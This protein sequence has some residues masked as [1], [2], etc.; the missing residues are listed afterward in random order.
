MKLR[1]V[2][3]HSD[4]K[5]LND[6]YRYECEHFENLLIIIGEKSD[7]NKKY[8]NTALFFSPTKKSLGRIIKICQDANLI[9]LNDLT[10]F[11]CKI[12][13]ALPQNI[14]IAWRFF[15][16]E[17]YG[18]KKKLFLSE[19][20]KQ[21]WQPG[22]S[23]F[24][25]LVK[26]KI[27]ILFK[28]AMTGQYHKKQDFEI[29][30]Q[31]INLFFGLFKDEYLL[32]KTFWP[33]LPP[34]LGL[35]IGLNKVNFR[36]I[37]CPKKSMIILGNSRNNFN[38]H[39]DIIDIVESLSHPKN[40]SF[41]L[42]FNYGVESPYAEEIRRRALKIPTVEIVND[43]M[44]AEA[45]E[46]LYKNASAL[47]LNAYRQMAVGNILA[48]FRNGVKVY[49][50]EKNITMQWLLREG[51]FV[52]PITSLANDIEKDNFKLTPAEIEHNIAQLAKLM[53]SYTK[54]DFQNELYE[55]VKNEKP[56]R[57]LN[58]E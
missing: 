17:L 2:H 23:K 1:I 39:A 26:K 24:F 31:R 51:F 5:F 8:H 13:L 20:T 41:K 10:Q 16:H 47:V 36:N 37:D 45:F 14:K 6:I 11:G 43:F 33:S 40:I 53:N 15:G 32:L 57:L 25:L 4:F 7:N 48:A 52:F 56:K 55:L 30:V 18:K 38:N 50:N 46:D 28:N 22:F 27:A 34:F 9:V 35:S 44:S 58:A 19:K 54:E 29:A 12:V 3:I 42:L 21:I 49:L